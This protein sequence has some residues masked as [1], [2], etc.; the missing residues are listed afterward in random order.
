MTVTMNNKFTM[1][2]QV[3]NIACILLLNKLFLAFAFL[4]LPS[5]KLNENFKEVI[6]SQYV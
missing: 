1:S 5:H 3:L 6:Y 2:A 4:V